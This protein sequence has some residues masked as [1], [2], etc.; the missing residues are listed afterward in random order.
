MTGLWLAVLLCGAPVG[1]GEFLIRSTKHFKIYHRHPHLAA[2]V[3]EAAEKHL[4]KLIQAI[5]YRGG[6]RPKLSKPFAIRIYRDLAE[7]REKTNPDARHFLSMVTSPTE[8][9]TFQAVAL[10]ALEHEI[11]H[12]VVYAYL[13]TTPV[14]VQE[15]FAAGG[16]RR[17]SA[18]AYR[19]AKQLLDA[20]EL[21]PFDKILR[22][23]KLSGVPMAQ[24]A[25]YLEARLVLEFLI[26]ARGG[27]EKLHKAIQS[28]A[29][30][31]QQDI[32]DYARTK[33]G[34]VT[35][36][37]ADWME[38][39]LRVSLAE[40]YGYR[41]LSRFDS[42]LKRYIEYR[43]READAQARA[44]PRALA[45]GWKYKTRLES[46]HFILYTSSSKPIAES[47][48]AFCES[49]YD[50]IGCAF[51]EADLFLAPKTAVNLFD[52]RS[53]YI[54]YLESMGMAATRDESLYPHFNLFTGAACISREG[55]ERDFV[56]QSMAHEITHG[57]TVSLMRAFGSPGAW[58]IEGIAHYVSVSVR[59]TEEAIALG[60][61][62]HTRHSQ[63]GSFVRVMVV[64]G[65]QTPLRDFLELPS[66]G[67]NTTG[68]H[69]Q[70]FGLFHFLE[71]GDG[72]KYREGFHRYLAEILQTGK[73]DIASFEKHVGPV[74]DIELRFLAYAGGL[75]PSSRR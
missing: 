18:E 46:E 50:A 37:P 42:D 44:R 2:E 3:A 23:T 1:P 70:C 10:G 4:E 52:K 69:A 65:K 9:A 17:A 26:Y 35:V 63:T 12:L 25:F 55:M 31:T 51:W 66:Q 27:M 22:I 54:A 15:G 38:K 34:K 73:G 72:G 24:D 43:I 53:E 28:A 14:W 48:L 75:G 56:Y 19:R 21:L 33:R 5:G 7:Y 6:P 45:A 39:P 41:D 68:H 32:R 57:V 59:A 40:D 36:Y 29:E 62:Y 20:N 67:L 61:I 47:L 30:R 16:Y 60:D 74:T 64:Q 8:I 13:P 49:V 71:H 11:T 58:V